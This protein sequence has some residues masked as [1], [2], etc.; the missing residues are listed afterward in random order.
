MHLAG[1]STGKGGVDKLWGI[2]AGANKSQTAY[3]C[4]IAS[5]TR[6]L[7]ETA[8]TNLYKLALGL[9]IFTII[10]NTVE[11]LVSILMGAHD[12]TLTLFGFGL[13]SIIEVI[14]GIGIFLMVRRIQNKPD[15]HK[16]SGEVTALKITGYSFYAL[17]A[18]LIG[19]S[20]AAIITHHHPIS[21]FWGIVIAAISITIMLVLARL[22]INTGRK[23][24]SKAIISDGNC[25]M[26]CAYM[27]CVLLASSLAYQFLHWAYLD[28][29]GSLGLCWF[30]YSEGKEALEGARN[31]E[32]SGCCC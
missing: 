17:I 32:K 20:I 13:D 28:V 12:E 25:T 19:S 16:S 22:K 26:V 21:T 6:R 11:G 9:S 14:S 30:C 24:N 4:P 8:T 2:V 10:Y 31:I 7:M 5:I 15:S 23:L 18:L 1:D 29:L 3:L 27:S